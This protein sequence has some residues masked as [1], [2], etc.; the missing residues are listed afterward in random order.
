[1]R[2][3]ENMASQRATDSAIE[4]LEENAGATSLPDVLGALI[5][6]TDSS[7]PQPQGTNI[8]RGAIQGFGE[9]GA[10]LVALE[11]AEDQSIPCER[12][13]TTDCLQARYR[14][15]DRV[16]VW[17]PPMRDA[18]GCILGRVSLPSPQEIHGPDS[19]ESTIRADG[20]LTLRCGKSQIS[21]KEDGKVLVKGVDVV[22]HAKSSQRI[23]GASV[24][25]N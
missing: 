16:L 23:K 3:P 21:L 15:G 14:V 24:R 19:S 12:L 10:I 4:G 25:I 1:M 7:P 11:D 18:M 6:Q 8:A 9:G 20:K 22:S 5:R 17:R 13:E 2:H